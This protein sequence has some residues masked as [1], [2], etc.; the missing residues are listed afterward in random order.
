MTSFTR[1]LIKCA[2]GGLID[3]LGLRPKRWMFVWIFGT[4]ISGTFV[5]LWVWV[6][7]VFVLEPPQTVFGDYPLRTNGDY[8][9][10]VIGFLV[11]GWVWG[12][13]MGWYL[14]RK[15]GRAR[16]DE[17]ANSHKSSQEDLR[18]HNAE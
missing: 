11:I 10:S 2:R 6:D 1:F 15:F 18:P 7:M 16:R 17:A 9:L 12:T 13:F 3:A 8:A 4:A 5:G 14:W